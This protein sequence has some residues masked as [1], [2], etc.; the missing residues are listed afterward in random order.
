[1]KYIKIKI[2]CCVGTK[3][4]MIPC[5]IKFSEIPTLHKLYWNKPF[6]RVIW[7]YIEKRLKNLH[8]L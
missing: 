6:W 1:M 3:F 5:V 4:Q 2:T 8:T 7:Q